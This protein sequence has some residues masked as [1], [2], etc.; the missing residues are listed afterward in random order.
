MMT[1]NVAMQKRVAHD[2]R[3]QWVFQEDVHRDDRNE[4]YDLLVCSW[5]NKNP[6]LFHRKTLSR[7]LRG[8]HNRKLPN[9]GC[10]KTDT[11]AVVAAYRTSKTIKEISEEFGLSESRIRRIARA[12]GVT[13]KPIFKPE[14][15]VND[16]Q[17]ISRALVSADTARIAK[18]L[19]VSKGHVHRTIRSH[20]TKITEA[21][22]G[23]GGAGGG[24]GGGR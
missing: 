14:K 23:A 11:A 22:R 3:I 20:L 12:A 7:C 10:Q 21:Y 5:C 15:S 6:I 17:I 2:G 24:S 8:I 18:L 19:G 16:Y 9:C 1:E 13:A 4:I